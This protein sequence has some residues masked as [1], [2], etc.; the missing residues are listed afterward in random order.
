MPSDDPARRAQAI[1]LA[2][3]DA[4]LALT[5]LHG[6]TDPRTWSGPAAS[7]HRFVVEARSRR[8]E[9]L[10]ADARRAADAIVAA[11]AEPD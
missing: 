4:H 10:L 1:R 7:M 2:C 11:A 5:R 6:T 3:D 9:G 8:I